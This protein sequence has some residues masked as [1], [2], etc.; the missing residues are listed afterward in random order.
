MLTVEQ[1]VLR[2]SFIGASDAPAVLGV[3]PWATPY[4]VWCEKTS[5]EPPVPK[6]SEPMY[7]GT[8]LEEVV[9]NE[10]ARRTGHKIRRRSETMVHKD[11]RFIGATLD[12]L[13]LNYPGGALLECKTASAWKTDEWG[14]P[15]SD[16]I[17]DPYLVQVQQQ[18][19]IT[20]YSVAFVAA[21]LGGNDFRVYEVRPNREFADAIVEADV[22]FWR[23]VESLEPPPPMTAADVARRWP[24]STP[25]K[26][27]YA[28]ERAL[29]AWSGA[30]AASAEESAARARADECK[31][32]IRLFMTDAETL[33]DG[34]G[35]VL[36]TIKNVARKGYTVEPSTCRQLSIKKP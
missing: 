10:F 24:R 30:L 9:A 18:L 5:S 19:L 20:G 15:G 12:R 4:D 22:E 29:L 21:L 2:R 13:V 26:V 25:G 6:E 1:L 7:W 16:D 35:K 34:E 3:S 31:D 36:A 33:L 11:H 27:V 23:L 17:P 28:D 8:V 14:E 32:A